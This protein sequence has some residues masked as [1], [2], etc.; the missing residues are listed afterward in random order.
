MKIAVLTSGIL[1]VP[2]VQGGAVEVLVDFYLEYNNL[3]RLHDITIYSVWHRDV[4]NNPAMKSDV[5]HYYYIKV[6]GWWA[7]L[8]KKI[9][10]ITHRKEYYH[11]TI[12]Y[13]LQNA[14]KDI[15]HKQFDI[16]LIENRPGYAL[17]LK[18][19]TIAKLVYHLH[20]EKLDNNVENAKEIYSA[21]TRIITVSDYIKSR[22]NTI[23]AN[24]NKCITIYNGINL[25]AFSN[26]KSYSKRAMLGFS[27]KDFI[28]VYSGRI[29]R[30]KGILELIE[31]MMRLISYPQIKLM[32]IGSSF[33]GNNTCDD[34][35]ILELKKK[36]RILNNRIVF[37]GFIPYEQMP[38]YLSIANIA[39]IPS[40]WNDPLP[41]TILEA[42]AIGLPIITT[43]RGGIPEE[44]AKENA[45]LLE[46]N[47]HFV[48][49]LANAIL[50]LYEHPEKR[51]AMS[52]ASIE[53]SKYF[54][55]ERYAREFFET[56]SNI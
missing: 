7:K 8:K 33:F 45:I 42:Q 10:Q 16:I 54:S 50:Y 48:D 24:D 1:P 22:V 37:T 5:N 17:K 35:F 49:S 3:H 44:V 14:I 12:E 43:K 40:V 34:H 26:S 38:D 56:I 19:I 31:S 25:N 27:E 30:E 4:E 53:R 13:Y 18:D 9:Y 29:N 2:A 39:I 36:A 21:A 55:K 51:E 41:T 23:H 15:R 46:T 52:R 20:N 11:Y 28:M 6:N 32:V 47:D